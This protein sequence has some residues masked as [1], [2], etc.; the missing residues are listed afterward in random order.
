MTSRFPRVCRVDEFKLESFE[1]LRKNHQS[2][3]NSGR[4]KK[5]KKKKKK[6]KMMMMKAHLNKHLVQLHQRHISTQAL[7][8][9]IP[10]H[11]VQRS[12]LLPDLLFPFYL[13]QPALRAKDVDVFTPD[14]DIAEETENAIPDL[15]AGGEEDVLV[16]IAHRRDILVH[17]PCHGREDAQAFLDD[18]LEVG[19]ASCL[20]VLDRGF[21]PQGL[22]VSPDLCYKFCLH[23]RVGGD[24]KQC[25]TDG[26]R[27]RVGS[28]EA[29]A[30]SQCLVLLYPAGTS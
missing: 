9:S 12:F 13:D 19:H 4:E 6:K 10:K 2:P 17:Y 29:I 8:S 7:P 26:R 22:R 15:G 25:C 5:K 1:K 20:R 18:G 23:A 30:A 16:R 21:W 28:R 11:Q 14:G 3:T 27:C 24:V